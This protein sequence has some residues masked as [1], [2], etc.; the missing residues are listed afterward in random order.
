MVKAQE[1]VE[2]QVA[3]DARTTRTTTDVL[4]DSQPNPTILCLNTSKKCTKSAIEKTVE[5]WIGNDVPAGQ[6]D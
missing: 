2:E 3:L 1:R 4:Y 5:S 6:W